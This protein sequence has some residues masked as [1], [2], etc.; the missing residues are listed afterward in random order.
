MAVP[1]EC[2]FEAISRFEDW[3]FESRLKELAESSRLPIVGFDYNALFGELVQAGQ[4]HCAI[5]YRVPP[6]NGSGVEI[7]IY[8]PG[9]DRAGLK[10]VDSYSLYR[11]CRRRH[12]GIW[13][14]DHS[15]A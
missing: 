2:S 10:S 14:V 1:L 7:D 11:A 3:E 4:G 8:D 9:P 13:V 12:G 5:V 6:I 15:P